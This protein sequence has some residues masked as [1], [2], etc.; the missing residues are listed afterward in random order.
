MSMSEKVHRV[1]L[2]D[3]DVARIARAVAWFSRYVDEKG[4]LDAG[5]RRALRDLRVRFEDWGEIFRRPRR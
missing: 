1:R 3:E 5:E 4:L 2:S